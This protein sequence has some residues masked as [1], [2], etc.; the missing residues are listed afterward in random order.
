LGLRCEDPNAKEVAAEKAK[1]TAMSVKEVVKS[2]ATTCESSMDT[3]DSDS[4]IVSCLE[5][6][7]EDETK[8]KALG[9]GYTMQSLVCVAAKIFYKNKDE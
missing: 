3:M 4:T 6:C 9:E 2:A 7:P 5:P 8:I 1:N